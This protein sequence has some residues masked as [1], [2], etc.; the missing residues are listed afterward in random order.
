MLT[1]II[2]VCHG[3]EWIDPLEGILKINCDSAARE[4]STQGVD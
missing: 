3:S 2:R 4:I 1:L